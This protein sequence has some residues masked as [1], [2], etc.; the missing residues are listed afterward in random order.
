MFC[1]SIL[2]TGIMYKALGCDVT[3]L[4]DGA[5]VEQLG[6]VEYRLFA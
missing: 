4:G 2:H 5:C 6:L 1:K 3:L